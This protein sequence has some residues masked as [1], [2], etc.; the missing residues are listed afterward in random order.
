MSGDPLNAV[1]VESQVDGHHWEYVD[2]LSRA[3]LAGRGQLTVMTSAAALDTESVPAWC[4]E[5]GV[6]LDVVDHARSRVAD[7]KWL[8]QWALDR[9]I[10][11]VLAPSGD[12]L[13][14]RIGAGG[15]WEPGITLRALLMRSPWVSPRSRT[16]DSVKKAL[17]SRATK[18]MSVTALH[19]AGPGTA[20]PRGAKLVRDVSRWSRREPSPAGVAQLELGEARFWFAV[21]G[22][23]DARK[24]VATVAEALRDPRLEGAGLLIAGTLA[25]PHEPRLLEQVHELRNANVPVRIVDRRLGED[26]LDAIVDLVSCVVCPHKNEGPS[27]IALKAAAAGQRSVLAGAMSLQRDAAVLSGACWS[28]LTAPALAL[29]FLHAMTVPRP[30]ASPT[31]SP[32]QFA[33]EFLLG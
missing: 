19:L 3:I 5:L 17:I 24:D 33:A 21:L 30:P 31:S 22:V 1:I 25:D 26:E 14:Y 12:R 32:T 29:A 27:G 18:H 11:T 4:Q 20:P 7:P 10:A 16:R 23:I 6:Q 15:G 2:Y 13:I 8:S 9:G 28:E